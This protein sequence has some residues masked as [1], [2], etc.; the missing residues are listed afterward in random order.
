MV[1]IQQK[2][3]AEGLAQVRSNAKTVLKYNLDFYET[4][5]WT[6][7]KKDTTF[8]LHPLNLLGYSLIR[9]QK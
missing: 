3:P 9:P 5:Y 6:Q 4:L 8:L 7:N 1:Y 2:Q